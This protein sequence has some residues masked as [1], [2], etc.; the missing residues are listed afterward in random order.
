[1]LNKKVVIALAA[2]VILFLGIF[3]FAQS[4]DSEAPVITLLG[5]EKVTIEVGKTYTDEG[6]TATDDVDGD[7]TDEIDIISNVDEDVIGTYYVTYNVSDASGNDAEEIKRTVYVVD[8]EVPLISLLGNKEVTIEVGSTY[9]DAG[10]TAVDNYD[11]VITNKIVTVNN[12][13]EDVIGTYTVTY[14]VT[15]SEENKALE[16]TRTVNVVDATNPV[17][18]LNGKADLSIEVGSTYTDEGATATD[19]YDE[20]ITD[21]IVTVNSVVTDKVGTYTVT[22]NVTDNRGNKAVEVVRTVNVVDTTKPVISLIG[23]SDET[24]ILE[25]GDTY[26]E[27]GFIA[28][29]N[30]DKDITDKVIITSTINPNVI[31]TYTVTYNVVDAIGNIAQT[32]TRTVIVRDTTAPTITFGTNG[33]DAYAKGASTTVN[34]TDKDEVNLTSLKYVWTTSNVE[35]T[36]EKFINDFTNN[37]TISSVN[38]MSGIY[39]L[40]ILAKD[41]TGN[42]AKVMSEKFY[43]DN[44]KSVISGVKANTNYNH[45][46]TPTVSDDHLVSSKLLIESTSQIKDFTSGTEISD[47]GRYVLTAK[48]AAGNETVVNFYLD[49]TA[50]T[51]KNG[52]NDVI[53]GIHFN[54]NVNLTVFDRKLTQVAINSQVFK[55]DRDKS[56][57]TISDNQYS[58]NVTFSYLLTEEGDYTVTATDLAGTIK[59]ITFT[60]DKTAPSVSIV[61]DAT[62]YL[63]AGIKEY[64]ELGSS[65]IDNYSSADNLTFRKLIEYVDKNGNFIKLPYTDHIDNMQLGRHKIWYYYKD[66]AGNE[67]YAIRNVYVVDT[68]KPVISLIGGSDETVILELGDTYEEPGFIATDN[69]DKDITDKVIITS[70]IN[71]NVIGTYTVTYNVVDAIGNIAQ[72]VTRTVIVRDTTAPTITFGTNGNDAYAKG[73]S[74]TVNATDKDEVNLTSL[75][76]VWTT[77]NVEPTDEKFINDFTNNAT[78]SSVNNMS[79]IYYLWILAKDKT[80]NTA[81]VMSEKFYI[82]NVNPIVD[83]KTGYHTTG[84]IT[85]NVTESNLKSINVYNQDKK[86]N[87][88]VSNGTIL[89][90]EA[91]YRIT[92]TDLAGNYSDVW[93]AI[94]RTNPTIEGVVDGTSYNHNVNVRVFDKFLTSVT[95]NGVSQS[96]INIVG[97]NNE[98]KELLLNITEEGTYNIVSKDKVG[99][100]TNATFAIDKTAPKAWAVIFRTN[101]NLGT[102]INYA[103]VG[104]TIYLKLSFNETL[105][106]FPIVKIANETINNYIQS[107]DANGN[108]YYTY[109]LTITNEI[110]SSLTENKN[111]PFEVSGYV[112][113]A[114]NVGTTITNP[115][116]KDFIVFDKT[117]LGATVSYNVTVPTRGNVTATITPN[118]ELTVTNNGGLLSYEFTDNGSFTFDL[119]DRAGNIEHVT[120][121]VSNIDRESP[122]ATVSYNTTNP[123]K[124]N[125]NAT[126]TPSEEVTVTN[127]GGLLGHEFTDNGSFTFEFVD[128]AG[129]IG[130]V[131]ATVSN[132]DKKSPTVSFAPNG[133]NTPAPEYNVVVNVSDLNGLNNE[134]IKYLWSTSN[135]IPTKSVWDANG[136]VFTSDSTLSTPTFDSGTYYL[137]IMAEDSLGN[138]GYTASE[139]YAIYNPVKINY[140]VTNTYGYNG[141]SAEIELID[142]LKIGNASSVE[143]SIYKDEELLATNK[144]INGTHKRLELKDSKILTT[145]FAPYGDYDYVS[146]GY[147]SHK[148]LGSKTT[149]PDKAIVTVVIN[150]VTYTKEIH[151]SLNYDDVKLDPVKINY[152]VTNTHGYNGYSAEIELTHDYTFGDASSVEMSIYKDEELLA[153]NKLINGTHKRLELKDSKILTTPFAPYGDYDYVSDGYWSHKWLGSKTVAPDK[154]IVTVVISGVTYTKEIHASLSLAPV[155]LKITTTASTFTT[156]VPKTF[157]VTTT[158]NDDAGEM[159][160][161]YFTLPVGATIEYQEG[162][163]GPWIPLTNVFGPATGFPLGNIATTFRGTFNSAGKY[164]VILDFKKVSDNTVV[165]SKN[166][167]VNVND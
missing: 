40:W 54:N 66:E 41:K 32:V 79:G 34:A 86:T 53:D 162:G 155:P 148:W 60:I 81:K 111:I 114:G 18:S 115:T 118:E 104:E 159:V 70:T 93:V 160:K 97:S 69:Y 19:N 20:V 152:L 113:I 135:D 107:K 77:S 122:T 27:P 101:K 1:M 126:I 7:L 57:F 55:A 87:A 17:I 139:A 4:G 82:D 143:M 132:I 116:N 141:Y 38:N 153:T 150:G 117:N 140:L 5:D 36:D 49:F 102:S 59:T 56:Y 158:P 73:A 64:T 58:S 121:V 167:T 157:T 30:Y 76:Y 37:A 48:D 8:E 43:I 78:I 71:P 129:N 138:I 92:A 124:G 154:A 50:P 15:D 146:D 47:E 125:V 137:L 99:N 166:I 136:T 95:K 65:A 61:G 142:G 105:G 26:E 130:S 6:A 2:I 84:D 25:L 28:T 98:N 110:A 11:G 119:K 13:N 74:T 83:L 127:N 21:K 145:P 106:T 23:G 89:T 120:A 147:W 80:G 35:P 165:G 44:V 103:T 128:T 112:D 52:N 94:D 91:T 96:P 90:E 151:A 164:N 51:I 45:S 14:N 144:L 42:T 108:I 29:D 67:G 161:A 149:A 16:V 62:K 88:V 100:T 131:T 72:T 33:N 134:N 63:E 12:V 75:K 123:T 39:Y 46:V 22:Y 156:N 24:V 3:S 85:I 163:I 68:T 31:G 10:A 109:P 9:T 133:S